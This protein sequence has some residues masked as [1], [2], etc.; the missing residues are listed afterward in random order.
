MHIVCKNSYINIIVIQAHNIISRFSSRW[1]H[2]SSFSNRLAKLDSDAIV[3]EQRVLL[4]M[5]NDV[6]NAVEFHRSH[7]ESVR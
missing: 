2:P 7:Y 4:V 3:K 1:L 6:L 5:F